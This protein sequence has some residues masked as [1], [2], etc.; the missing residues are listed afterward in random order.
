MRYYERLLGVVDR[1]VEPSAKELERI[2]R[3]HIPDDKDPLFQVHYPDPRLA[4]QL[5]AGAKL[6][7][8]DCNDERRDA[9]VE[10]LSPIEAEI[11]ASI[12]KPLKHYGVL[13]EHIGEVVDE[14]KRVASDYRYEASKKREEYSTRRNE[15]IAATAGS[16]VIGIATAGILGKKKA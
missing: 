7:L 14:M 15:W 5:I 4:Y 3:Y 11:H 12:A 10:S 13:R 6:K 16:A 2:T 1:T 8:R 9:V